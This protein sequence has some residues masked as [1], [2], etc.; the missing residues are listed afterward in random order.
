MARRSTSTPAPSTSIARTASGRNRPRTLALLLLLTAG[1]LAVPVP[2]LAVSDGQGRIDVRVDDG[3]SY[4]YSYV[5]SVYEAPVEER[6]L[7]HGDVLS[8]TSVASSDRRAVEYFRW[9]GEPTSKAGHYEQDAPP[10]QT[11]RLTIRISPRYGQR[12]EG[13]GWNIDLAAEFGDGVVSV[14]P[15]DEPL[16]LALTRG[17]RP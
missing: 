7:R 15:E 14:E 13:N 1:A 5:N 8:I 11:R 2:V 6:H 16:G 3:A 12:L 10:N 17:W 9:D 4:T